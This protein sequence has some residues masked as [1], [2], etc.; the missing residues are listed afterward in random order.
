[1]LSTF[2]GRELCDVLQCCHLL[3]MRSQN[4][5]FAGQ[6]IAA[7]LRAIESVVDAIAYGL[8]DACQAEAGNL[9]NQFNSLDV[10]Y[11]TLTDALPSSGCM[12][13]LCPPSL[14][15]AGSVLCATVTGMY[16]TDVLL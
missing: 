5:P 14:C 1:M 2:A 10:S 16:Y 15:G 3:L 13:Q 7:A 9:T 8:I 6:G 11:S 4:I 12:M